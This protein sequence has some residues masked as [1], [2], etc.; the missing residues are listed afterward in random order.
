M[1]CPDDFLRLK[2][3]SRL[4]FEREIN[5]QRMK[6]VYRHRTDMV[7]HMVDSLEQAHHVSGNISKILLKCGYKDI[8]SLFVCFIICAIQV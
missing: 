2:N 4:K 8:Q 7:H 6:A 1:T 3:S 5:G